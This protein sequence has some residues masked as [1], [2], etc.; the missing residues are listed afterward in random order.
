MR[1]LH[2]GFEQP[3]IS[4]NGRVFAVRKSDAEMVEDMLRLDA[5][6]AQAK[7]PAQAL[8]EKKNALLAYL[9]ELLGQGAR[10]ALA[11]ILR[12]ES[13]GRDPGAAGLARVCEALLSAAA[14]AYAGA[15]TVR[16]GEDA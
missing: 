7:G 16:Y 6:L 11:D 5:R 10:E 14:R 2:I 8:E 15:F 9:D 1:E 4:I 3:K 12:A 13:G